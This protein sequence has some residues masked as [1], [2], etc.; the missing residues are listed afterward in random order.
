MFF[1]ALFEKNTK[2]NYKNIKLHIDKNFVEKIIYFFK[3]K[4]TDFYGCVFFLE[5]FVLDK[6]KKH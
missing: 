5:C 4:F 2:N 1:Y 6:S 3:N